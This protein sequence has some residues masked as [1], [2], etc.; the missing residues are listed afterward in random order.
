MKLNRY[1]V[2]IFYHDDEPDHNMVIEASSPIIAVY[3]ACDEI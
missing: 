3:T 2:E 1:Q